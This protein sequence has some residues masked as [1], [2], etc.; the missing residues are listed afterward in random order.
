MRSA[1]FAIILA[2]AGCS[3]PKVPATPKSECALALEGFVSQQPARLRAVPATCTIEDAK[4]VLQATK[5][6]GPGNLGSSDHRVRLHFFES[7]TFES[8]RVW[9]D[10]AGNIVLVEADY[11]R[12]SPEQYLQVFGEPEA[13]LDYP[14]GQSVVPAGEQ[15]WLSRGVSIVHQPGWTK[16]V[17]HVGIFR[18]GMTLQEYET[19]YQYTDIEDIDDG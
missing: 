8:V 18:A 2:S 13:R 5:V 4:Q 1:T 11:P 16:G 17:I 19:S 6:Q 7:E 14:W 12:A 15:L 10:E 3:R 9:T